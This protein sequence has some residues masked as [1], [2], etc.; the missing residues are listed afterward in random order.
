MTLKLPYT[1]GYTLFY[2]FTVQIN[3]YK[4]LVIAQMKHISAFEG[5]WHFKALAT[6][7]VEQQSSLQHLYFLS[8]INILTVQMSTQASK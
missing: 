2:F 4:Q 3:P 1:H 8:S 7:R 5:L 6:P